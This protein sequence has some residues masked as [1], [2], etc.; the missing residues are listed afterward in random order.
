MLLSIQ[1]SFDGNEEMND[2]FRGKGTTKKVLANLDRII[3]FL[4][5]LKFLNLKIRI[6]SGSTIS[7]EMLDYLVEDFPDHQNFFHTLSDKLIKNINEDKKDNILINFLL[8]NKL[9]TGTINY[10]KEDGI[11]YSKIQSREWEKRTKKSFKGFVQ[12]RFNILQTFKQRTECAA[13]ITSFCIAPDK[14]V[15]LCHRTFDYIIPEI[16]KN[17]SSMNNFVFY[18]KE[19]LLHYAY[20]LTSNLNFRININQAIIKEL[21]ECG[22]ISEIYRNPFYSYI[23][24]RH[25]ATKFYCYMDNIYE[26][27]SYNVQS[28]NLF[29]V[30]GNGALEYHIKNVMENL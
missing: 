22:E 29:K 19:K 5:S 8:H 16:L 11:K 21:I 15:H 9:A 10:S 20:L 12:E 13:G 7:N 4:N 18:D 3:D 26:T 1:V 23:L 25:I 14:S 27:G 24:A 17:N 2:I 28:I 6:S 30:Y